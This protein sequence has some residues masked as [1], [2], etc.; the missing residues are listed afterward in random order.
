MTSVNKWCGSE[1]GK[2]S[3]PYVPLITISNSQKLRELESVRHNGE[4]LPCKQELE[5]RASPGSKPDFFC[6]LGQVSA[7]LLPLLFVIKEKQY[8][9][10]S[11][12]AV[13]LLVSSYSTHK[14]KK[15][16]TIFF[17][18]FGLLTPPSSCRPPPPSHSQSNVSSSR[19]GERRARRNITA[20]K[21]GCHICMHFTENCTLSSVVAIAHSSL[22]GIFEFSLPLKKQNINCKK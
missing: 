3:L 14:K 19:E 13:T 18:P 10:I 15:L 1:D 20:C 11:R 4:I 16:R 8:S 12:N 5:N 21:L 2:K 17:F 6:N 22:T 9:L 7:T